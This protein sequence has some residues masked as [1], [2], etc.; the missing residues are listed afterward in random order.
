M[1]R[2]GHL[3]GVVSGGMS[4]G[5]HLHDTVRQAGGASLFKE[6]GQEEGLLA[7]VCQWQRVWRAHLGG[8]GQAFKVEGG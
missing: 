7:E 4:Q 5:C 2:D 1:G 3:K 8:L 6:G